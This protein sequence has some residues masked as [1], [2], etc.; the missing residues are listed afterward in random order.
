MSYLEEF[1]VRIS[2]REFLRFFQLWEEYC[3]NDVVD[4]A[5]LLELL[6]MIKNSDMAKPFG[7]VAETIVPL[8][9][10]IEDP[11]ARYQTLKL[12]IDLQTTNSPLLADLA[13]NALKEKYDN[14]ALFN[15]RIRLTG[16]RARDNFQN[17]I[18][19]HELLAHLEAGNFVY[20]NGGWGTGEIME[21]SSLL[22]QAVIEFENVSGKKSI[23]YINAF[24]TLVP[25]GKEHFLARRFADPDKLEK[26]AKED[27]VA[28]I[29]LLLQDLGPK[30]AAEIKDEL[31]ELVIPEKEWAKWWQGARAK[32]KKDPLIDAPENLKSP[33]R[34]R[35][36]EI[37]QKDVLDKAISNKKGTDEFIL[38]SYNFMRDLPSAQKNE[39]LTKT[40]QDQLTTLLEDTTLTKAQELQII[41]LLEML[42]DHT[43]SGKQASDK[44]K[45]LSLT[46]LDKAINS[47]QILALKK[48]A[49]VLIQEHKE[50]W[51]DLFLHLLFTVQQ[52]AL[53]DYILNELNQK[54]VKAKLLEKLEALKEQPTIQP[55]FFVWFF[56]KILGG[57]PEIPFSDKKGQCQFFESLLILFS[58]IENKPEYRE[59]SKKIY[60]ILS[61]KR[62]ENVRAIIEGTDIEFIKEFLLLTSKCQSLTDH[63]LKILRS[64]AEVVHPSL[65]HKPHLKALK[66]VDG[67]TIWTTESGYLK[68]Q[69]RLKQI[70]TKEMLDNAKEVEAARAL[71][72]LRE[73]SEYKFACEKRARLQGE[74][75]SLSELLNRARVITSEDIY[76]N[77]VSIGSIVSLKNTNDHIESYTILGPWDVDLDNNVLS[78]QSKFAQAMIGCKLKESFQFKDEEYTVEDI[79]SF[80]DK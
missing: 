71:G 34:L 35:K 13:L 61:N 21:S 14:N 52:S 46:E 80:L 78:F 6:Q 40:L 1:K 64:L 66:H 24:K 50:D 3:T 65:S 29:K 11:K 60:G 23:N 49:L 74:M 56:Q 51:Q 20:H 18:A 70:A 55:D 59:L 38:T 79:K 73:N 58:S 17:A 5:E 45:T 33:F 7:K 10:M 54:E 15:E 9:D 67:H 25:I 8:L 22:E 47:I 44:I 69:E 76:P 43:I 39:G 2:S 19:N 62:Y 26:E 48:R 42:F 27:P 53:R 12:L 30:N 37:S 36:V 32:L 75:K 72:D 63:D 28:I 4:T 77:E 68:T 16:L 31:E 57:N 41:I